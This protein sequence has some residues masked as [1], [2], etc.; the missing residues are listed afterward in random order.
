MNVWFHI[1][2][3]FNQVKFEK[4]CKKTNKYYTKIIKKS[5]KKIMKALSRKE[6]KYYL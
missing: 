5:Y 3:K 4:N 6:K 1:I 2:N